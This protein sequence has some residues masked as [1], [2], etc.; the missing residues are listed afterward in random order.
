MESFE[1][2]TR[3]TLQPYVTGTS[4]LGIRCSDGVV[5]GADTLVSYGSLAKNRK[6]SRMMEVSKNCAL[7]FSGEYSD[8]QEIKSTVETLMI[9]EFCLGDKI[10]IKPRSVHQYLARVMYQRR[11]KMDPLWNQ[12]V[13]GGVD[14]NS[15]KSFLG[16]VDLYGTNF[17]NETIATG[18]GLYIAL[19]LLRKA[20]R[21]DITVA[22]AQTVIKDCLRVLFYRDARSIDTVQLVTV[23][24]EGT[25]VTDPFKIDTKWDFK[26]FKAGSRNVD[27]ST[28]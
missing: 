16:L 7:A 4:V 9:S 20:Y 2:P 6:T 24:K 27:E 13:L 21:P 1:E 26:K 22:E 14:E 25:T 19:P 5:L 17:E 8:F 18:Y 12:V 3:R 15:G 28:W 11:N 23:T 10:T